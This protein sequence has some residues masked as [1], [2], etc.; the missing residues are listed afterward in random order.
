MIR[1]K[2]GTLFRTTTH[3]PGASFLLST[4][5]GS[6]NSWSS[7]FVRPA[8]LLR[9]SISHPESIVHIPSFSASLDLRSYC[10]DSS[11]KYDS[12]LCSKSPCVG[13]FQ[14]RCLIGPS[15]CSSS[16]YITHQSS[17]ICIS[18]YLLTSNSKARCE[19][20]SVYIREQSLMIIEKS[21]HLR[22]AHLRAWSSLDPSKP[23]LT[24]HSPAC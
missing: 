5:A 1:Q 20:L 18:C 7:H 21:F 24:T 2:D 17:H 23:S 10:N 11:N 19:Y 8:R 12:Q 13:A 6:E 3:V 16:S 4:P 9:F 22:C 14:L 15:S